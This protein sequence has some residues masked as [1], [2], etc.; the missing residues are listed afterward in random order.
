MD[1][2]GEDEDEHSEDADDEPV[3]ED[4]FGDDFDDFEEGN[5]DD[6]FE[7]F[8]DSFKQSS[9]PSLPIAPQLMLPFVR[10]DT[11]T[12]LHTAIMLISL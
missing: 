10:C 12:Y 9:P 4:D 7:G 1:E 8:E 6:G 5:E 11:K 2:N 3:E